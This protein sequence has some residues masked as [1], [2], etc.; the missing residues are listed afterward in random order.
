MSFFKLFVRFGLSQEG[1]TRDLDL[2]N[3]A[4]RPTTHNLD[5]RR[6]QLQHLFD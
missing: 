2:K 4:D 1:I 6:P 3:A 5:F